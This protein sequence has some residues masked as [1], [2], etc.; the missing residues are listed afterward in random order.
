MSENDAC[1]AVLLASEHQVGCIV[2]SGSLKGQKASP[3]ANS[4]SI[5]VVIKP[6]NHSDGAVDSCWVLALS[7]R[8]RGG[9]LG[10]SCSTLRPSRCCGD[11]TAWSER[12][13]LAAAILVSNGVRM[14]RAFAAAPP[15]GDVLFV[16]S[17]SLQSSVC[18]ASSVSRSAI[19]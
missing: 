7:K 2:A 3:Q 17:P 12:I 10:A 11:A 19:L 14:V 8:S 4:R 18:V 16:M 13:R 1:L 15:R 9:F 6:S 5:R